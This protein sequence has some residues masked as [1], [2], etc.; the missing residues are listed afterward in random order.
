MY[1]YRT[2]KGILYARKYIRNP[3]S[4]SLNI[5]SM[6]MICKFADDTCMFLRFTIFDYVTRKFLYSG[7]YEHLDHVREFNGNL[8]FKL[9]EPSLQLIS[10]EDSPFTEHIACLQSVININREPDRI[11]ITLDSSEPEDAESSASYEP[12]EPS[13]PEPIYKTKPV[14]IKE[15][16]TISTQVGVVRPPTPEP[17]PVI[18]KTPSASSVKIS[19]KSPEPVQEEPPPEPPQTKI[20]HW[21]W[22]IYYMQLRW[23]LKWA[24][25]QELDSNPNQKLLWRG[26][27]AVECGCCGNLRSFNVELW[28]IFKEKED[29]TGFNFYYKLQAQE[30]SSSVR[31][32][33]KKHNIKSKPYIV[34][35]T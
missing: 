19:E 34:C 10:F 5:M 28:K 20:H 30:F 24:F 9:A 12:I 35:Y 33:D 16:R 7:K 8:L 13:T 31:L 15:K 4:G 26:V 22:Y 18:I 11:S 25:R 2:L 3:Q 29:A 32:V 17:E 23:K 21:L 6:H 1:I 14:D 27:K